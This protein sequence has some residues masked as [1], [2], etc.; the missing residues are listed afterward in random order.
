MREASDIVASY[1]QFSFEEEAYLIQIESLDIE[2]LWGRCSPGVI[3]EI[4][5]AVSS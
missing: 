4:Y 3:R 5:P 2:I 1:T